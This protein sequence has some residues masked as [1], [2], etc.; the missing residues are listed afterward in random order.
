MRAVLAPVL[1]VVISSGVMALAMAEPSP[2][3]AAASL[4][5]RGTAIVLL[6]EVHDNAVQHAMRQQAFRSL[7]ESGARPA[8]LMEQFDRER[9][10]AIDAAR[11]KP[12]ADAASIVAAGAGARSG[13]NWSFYTPFVELAL[14]YGLPIV[15]ANVSR[16]DARRVI[17][18]GLAAEGFD[19]RVPAQIEEAHVRDIEASHCGKVD[20]PTA[21]RMAAAQ[22]ARDQFMARMVEAN[23]ARGVVLL[24]GN[25]HVR[26]DIGVPRWLAPATREQSRSIGL[27]EAGGA[28]STGY[29]LA[30]TTPRQTREDP[31]AAMRSP[32][33]PS[34]ARE[35]RS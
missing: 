8:L 22:V 5:L 18:K 13:W 33:T 34:P 16:A 12:D 23:A 15:A 24:A 10:P 29:D 30:L 7:L 11:A 2:P 27:L 1:A 6:G 28:S 32:P 4:D 26:N 9:Q 35:P 25:G 17:Q 20:A 14:Q 3:L 19:P 31:C 21:R